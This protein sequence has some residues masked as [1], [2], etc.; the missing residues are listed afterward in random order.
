MYVHL[1]ENDVVFGGV[2][3]EGSL[4]RLPMLP[5][6]LLPLRDGALAYMSGSS[7]ISME[8]AQNDCINE[9]DSHCCR[10]QS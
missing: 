10:F 9:T 6:R 8:V 5:C 4:S 3:G 7:V 2:K 1:R